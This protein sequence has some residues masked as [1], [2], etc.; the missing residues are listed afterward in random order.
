MQAAQAYTMHMQPRHSPTACW[1]EAENW[2]P[3]LALATR[4]TDADLP[5]LVKLTA[6]GSALMFRLRVADSA[7]AIRLDVADSAVAIRLSVAD[8]AWLDCR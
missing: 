3:A 1:R 6:A 7:V 4:L 5:F 8:S 2:C